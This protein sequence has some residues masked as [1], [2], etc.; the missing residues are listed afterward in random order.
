M[1]CNINRSQDSAIPS[2]SEYSSAG[3]SNLNTAWGVSK[4]GIIMFNGISAEG[5]D[6]F[7]PAAYGRV[8]NPDSVKERVDM[9]LAHP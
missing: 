5:V 6:P 2:V 8:T 7:Y 9:C 4:T 1:I 3:S